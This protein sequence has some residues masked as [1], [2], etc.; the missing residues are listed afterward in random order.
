[1]KRTKTARSSV[2]S[3]LSDYPV[4]E[5]EYY[6]DD[7][8]APTTVTICSTKETGEL[9]SEWLTVSADYAIPVEGVR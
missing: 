2:S 1:M 6:F 7:A 5:L 9:S 4:F 8:E 3:A